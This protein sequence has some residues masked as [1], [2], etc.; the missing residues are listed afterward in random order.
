MMNTSHTLSKV[1]GF[2]KAGDYVLDIS[3]DDG[4]RQ[5]IDFL[6]VLQGDLFGPLRDR[7][8]FDRVVIDSEFH[9]LVW[10]NGADFDSGMLHDWPLVKED[11]IAQ[12]QGLS[13]SGRQ[14]GAGRPV[15]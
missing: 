4:T 1:T 13:A 8:L 5:V 3:F 6:P 9:T 12:C 2:R 15:R 7:A 11:F 10:P 14:K